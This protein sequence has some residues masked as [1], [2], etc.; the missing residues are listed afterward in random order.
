VGVTDD[1]GPVPRATIEEDT[2]NPM[3]NYW[4]IVEERAQSLQAEADAARRARRAA[5]VR[6]DAS[7]ARQARGSRRGSAF[8]TTGFAR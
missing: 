8:A 1:P 5:A 2:M 4:A 3:F 7:R 6:R